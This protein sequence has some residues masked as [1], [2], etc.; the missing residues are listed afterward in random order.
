MIDRKL[1]TA[2][3]T[4]ALPERA[5]AIMLEQGTLR[6]HAERVV[7]RLDAA[8]QRCVRLAEDAGFSFAAPPQGLFG[9]VETGVDAERL[10]AT[11]TARAGCWRRAACSMPCRGRAR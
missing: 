5:L 2:L 6:R 1:L 8:R 10:A 11:C 9:W 3:T 7:T 4:P